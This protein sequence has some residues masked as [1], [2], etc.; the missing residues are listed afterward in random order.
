MNSSVANPIIPAT[1]GA[2]AMQFTYATGGSANPGG[3]KFSADS[4]TIASVTTITIDAS[5]SG[6]N[7]QALLKNIL[8]G[9]AMVLVDPNGMR[10]VFRVSVVT[11]GTSL[12]PV[13]FTVSLL[14]SN[15]TSFINGGKYLL[16]DVVSMPLLF[17]PAS[18]PTAD[19]HVAGQVYTLAGAMM[20]SAG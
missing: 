9:T 20:V 2:I 3:G 7:I 15:A 5:S 11:P 18:T 6:G 13:V 17:A 19:P 1:A 4:D 8:P 14:R 10:Q 16:Q 12:Q